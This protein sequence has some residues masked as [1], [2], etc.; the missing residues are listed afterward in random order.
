MDVGPSLSSGGGVTI[1]TSSTSEAEVKKAEECVGSVTKEIGSPSESIIMPPHDSPVGEEVVTAFCAESS[2]GAEDKNGIEE[3]VRT[4][5]VDLVP[6]NSSSTTSSSDALAEGIA[7]IRADKRSAAGVVS[8]GGTS[9]TS[10]SVEDDG[11]NNDVDVGN[12]DDAEVSMGCRA[13]TETSSSAGKDGGGADDTISQAVDDRVDHEL[14]AVENNNISISGESSGNDNPVRQSLQGG[15]ITISPL[16]D[17]DAGR[18]FVSPCPDKSTCAGK[19]PVEVLSSAGDGQEISAECTTSDNL[20]HGRDGECTTKIITEAAAGVEVSREGEG[21]DP[22]AGECLAATAVI[23]SSFGKFSQNRASEQQNSAL[24][25]EPGTEGKNA[26]DSKP[27][28]RAEDEESLNNNVRQFEQ[29]PVSS[30]SQS[31]VSSN[32]RPQSPCHQKDEF[33]QT[34]GCASAGAELSAAVDAML[35]GGA[36]SS[37]RSTSGADGAHDDGRNDAH[38][39]GRNDARDD[40]RGSRGFGGKEDASAS[41]SKEERFSAAPSSGSG[42]SGSQLGWGARAGFHRDERAASRNYRGDDVL[43]KASSSAGGVSSSVLGG[44]GGPV[45]GL[46]L[47]TNEFLPKNSSGSRSSGGAR[48]VVGEKE[49]G[50]NCR[51]SSGR[52]TTTSSEEVLLPSTGGGK[53]KKSQSLRRGRR[54]EE[55]AGAAGSAEQLLEA[56]L[57]RKPKKNQK[58]FDV[59]K[60][61]S[62][63]QNKESSNKSTSIEDSEPLEYSQSRSDIYESEEG[64]SEDEYEEKKTSSCGGSS[65]AYLWQVWPGNSKYLCGGL[66]MTGGD[67]E[68]ALTPNFSYAH[69]GVL[70]LA[71]GLPLLIGVNSTLRV[72]KGGCGDDGGGGGEPQPP[73]ESIWKRLDTSILFFWSSF[74]VSLMLLYGVS[75]TDPGSRV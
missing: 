55:E 31:R 9:P 37:S 63:L 57:L 15:E 50:E 62:P 16:H 75:Y 19:S 6:N 72:L 23:T 34:S 22:A 27:L 32:P 68:C 43:E 73:T 1:G 46:G 26:D 20:M 36:S 30:N 8:A 11:G 40:A 70:M 29:L 74:L 53:K 39:D 54:F 24:C 52:G 33:Y 41:S 28:R 65:G 61:F 44:G 60:E 13:A 17:V 25:N 51:G 10:S 69:L 64:T 4:N 66:C 7:N 35:G 49:Q 38:D 67:T 58:L 21:E 12:N 5:D 42:G 45:G 48:V 14:K 2:S 59:N 3:Q 18:E 47:S 56:G 71:V